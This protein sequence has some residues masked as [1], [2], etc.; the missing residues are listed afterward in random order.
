MQNFKTV[1]NLLLGELVLTNFLLA[2]LLAWFGL[3]LELCWHPS[4]IIVWWISLKASL[5]VSSS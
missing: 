4:S 5:T 2:G 1:A 3:D